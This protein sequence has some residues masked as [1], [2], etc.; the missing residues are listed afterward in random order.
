MKLEYAGINIL[1]V[2]TF[3]Y[4]TI[5]RYELSLKLLMSLFPTFGITREVPQNY[6]FTL[7]RDGCRCRNSRKRKL[8]VYM[9]IVL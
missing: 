7:L 5:V 8:R 6:I 3:T 9:G 4:C 2:T 1:L